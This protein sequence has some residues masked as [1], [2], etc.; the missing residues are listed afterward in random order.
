VQAEFVHETAIYP[1]AEYQF[2]HP[3]TQ[4]V[5]LGS[6]LREGQARTHAVV[7]AALIELHGNDLDEQAALLAHHY[8]AAR[9]AAAAIRWN[10]R[11]AALLEGRDPN[12][13][14]HHWTRVYELVGVEPASADQSRAAIRACIRLL[15]LG[16][17]LGVLSFVSG[18]ALYGRGRALAARCDEPDLDVRLTARFAEFAWFS[19]Q[20][21]IAIEGT[22]E[23]LR[24]APRLMDPE[25]Y[26]GL[27]ASAATVLANAGRAPDGLSAVDD[28]LASGKVTTATPV[29]LG[30][31]ERMRAWM[32]LMLGRLGESQSSLDRAAAL[33]GGR[34][35]M[36]ELTQIRL[37]IRRGF[38]EGTTQR[39]ARFLARADDLGLH[40][41]RIE[42]RAWLAQAHLFGG[43]PDVA[44]EAV[45][46]A[47]EIA[48][49]IG[50]DLQ[51]R[52]GAAP[53]RARVLSA[54]GEVEAA[55]KAI[56]H[57]ALQPSTGPI[58]RLFE[59]IA[60]AEVLIDANAADERTRIESSLKEASDIAKRTGFRTHQALIHT[61]RAH[62]ARAVG[63]VVGWE[64]EL[65]EALRIY[66]EADATG[67]MERI[68]KELA[69]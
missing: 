35:Q 29:Q 48:N 61:Q 42:Y 50:A 33:P 54:L 39:I 22:E 13:E 45:E 38:P 43:R 63:D 55:R 58:E 41:F 68:T 16:R 49:E 20:P 66:T 36:Q 60:I 2:K 34:S 14:R 67:W 37:L 10:E 4:E 6:Q 26:A 7:A 32:L 15:Y 46:A 5:A 64:R 30:D 9:D 52:V 23:A 65:R 53:L 59:L 24:K 56:E 57:F 12:A 1:E 11:A 3:L 27:V 40:S 8:E 47:I 19:G 69:S 21:D 28:A 62:L 25:Q 44:L 18:Q 17:V 51:L 31:L